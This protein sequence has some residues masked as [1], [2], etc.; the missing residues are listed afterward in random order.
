MTLIGDLLPLFRCSSGLRPPFGGEVDA[1][2][3]ILRRLL[4]ATAPL[5][6][7]DVRTEAL[8]HDSWEVSLLGAVGLLA[9]PIV[10]DDVP[11]GVLVA[12]DH[13][14][15]SWSDRDVAAL[16]GIAKVA[17]HQVEITR[18]AKAAAGQ[19]VER[20]ERA[21]LESE[22]RFR[23]L[24]ENAPDGIYVVQDD[25]IAY[26]NPAAVGLAGASCPQ[27]LVGQPSQRLLEPPYLKAV[28]LDL[29]E[30]RDSVSGPVEDR[31]TRL[32]GTLIDVE[33]SALPYLF[34][35]RPAA[36]LLVR[37]IGE[38]RRADLAIHRRDAELQL[39][40]DQLP[41]FVWSTDCDLR[42]QSMR[43]GRLR[44]A[45]SGDAIG[46]PM[47]DLF[48]ACDPNQGPLAVQRAA[49][50][51]QAGTYRTQW[52]GRTYDV[53]VEALRAS[54]GS[55]VGTVGV[56]MDV[57]EQLQVDEQLK[58]AEQLAGLGQLAAGVAHEMN[59]ILG[60]VLATA[61]A[62]ERSGLPPDPADLAVLQKAA[63]RGGGITGNLLGF[64]RKGMY[65]RARV[66]LVTAIER[67][68]SRVRA[69]NPHLRVEWAFAEGL[70]DVEGDE[71]QL[72]TALG[73]LCQNAVDAMPKGGTLT[74][75]ARAEDHDGRPDAGLAAGRW[76]RVD[77]Q[78][79][80]EGMT[81]AVARRAVEPF[82]T[83]RPLGRGVGLGLSMADGVIR[84]HGGELVVQSQSGLGTTVTFHLP[85]LPAAAPRVA[86]PAIQPS[87]SAIP[88]GVVLVVDDDEWVR[89]STG[90]LVTSMGYEVI[91]ANGGEAGLAVY[92][93][94]GPEI[95]AV[96]L[97]MRMPG[98][99]GAETLRRLVLIDPDVRV[100]LCTGYERDQVSQSLF[101]T[102]CVG[103]LGKPYGLQELK[104]QLRTLAR[105]PRV[106]APAD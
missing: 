78:D 73:H 29:V 43:G 39:L 98:M 10:V 82:F 95:V 13:S 88:R 105:D 2:R 76:V 16:T 24:V 23:A 25:C 75:T 62:L 53:L 84:N 89:F 81:E 35:G 44:Q 96:L 101:D 8:L 92:Q 50:T 61:A 12:F 85:S 57:S 77:V 26:V 58:S 71:D 41:V 79:T 3:S 99:D 74:I 63:R 49:V 11:L 31:L 72:S 55:I 22:A 106:V 45:P 56:A 87:A 36:L 15:R 100:I 59:N 47:R 46:M 9:V 37:D 33:V 18:A 51:G 27:D 52:Q 40:A 66:G 104:H 93:A 38:R 65:K 70:L 28:R 34:Q 83:T 7:T 54:D 20:N 17:A 64:A 68:G 42:L 97:D 19:D 86:V 30:G 80:G 14:P 67:T 90:R 48:G 69:A 32:D 102:D 1:E 6:F 91:E 103:F 94:R 4:A 60:V 21:L 5:A